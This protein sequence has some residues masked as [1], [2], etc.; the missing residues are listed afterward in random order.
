MVTR[1]EVDG[2]GRW[3]AGEPRG[4]SVVKGEGRDVE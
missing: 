3:K 1:R 2:V 4:R